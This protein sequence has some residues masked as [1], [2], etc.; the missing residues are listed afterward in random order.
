MIVQSTNAR[1]EEDGR[2]RRGKTHSTKPSVVRDQ[3]D[4]AFVGTKSNG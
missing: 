3:D 1:L 2:D 4:R